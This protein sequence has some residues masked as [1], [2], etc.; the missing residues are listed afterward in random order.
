MQ[1]PKLSGTIAGL[2]LGG[3]ATFGLPALGLAAIPVWEVQ[4][5]TTVAVYGANS[6]VQP[7]GDAINRGDNVHLQPSTQRGL[8]SIVIP[9]VLYSTDP[10]T[11]TATDMR[12][13]VYNVDAGGLPTTVLGVASA[14][15]TF[16]GSDLNNNGPSNRPHIY[17]VTDPITFN[18]DGQNIL[19]PDDFAFDFDDLTPSA[20]PLLSVWLQSADSVDAFNSTPFEGPDAPVR[21]HLRYAVATDTW[22]VSDGGV[23]PDGWNLVAQ[24]NVPE[25]ASLVLLGTAGLAIFGRR[26]RA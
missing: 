9:V 20:N 1:L 8:A 26:R 15:H 11:Y 23:W 25:P 7:N 10:E 4:L 16:T 2:A 6:Y 19:L 22:S 3:V 21:N 5:D 12:V 17:A 14:S 24:V 18:F 13:T